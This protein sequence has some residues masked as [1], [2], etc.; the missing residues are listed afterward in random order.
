VAGATGLVTG[1]GPA[2][3]STSGTPAP[4]IQVHLANH[5]LLWGLAFWPK[6]QG[7][8]LH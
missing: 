2:D 5:T 7:L 8:P 3:L 1:Y 4:R 6:P